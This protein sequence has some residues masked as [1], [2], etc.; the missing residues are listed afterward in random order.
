MERR[1][2]TLSDDAV[3]MNLFAGIIALAI[4]LGYLGILAVRVNELPLW[5]VLLVGFAMM[6]ASFVNALRED[7]AS[8]R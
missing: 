6:A 7:S 3:M 8:D 2:A 1:R 5:I 4:A